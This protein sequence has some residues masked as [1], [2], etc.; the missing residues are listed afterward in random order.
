MRC[1]ST[2]E[3]AESLGLSQPAVSIGIRQLEKLIGMTLFERLHRRLHP[4]EEALQLY[5]EVRPVFSLMRDFSMR[6]QAIRQGMSGKLRIVTTPPLGHTI[7]PVAL[8]ELLRHRA[9]VSVSYD[10][11]RLADVIEAVQNGS[12][13]IGLAMA[14]EHHPALHVEVLTRTHMVCLVP[15]DSALAKMTTVSAQ[16]LAATGFIGIETDSR[17]GQII[18]AAFE[19]DLASYNP[20][21]EV[22][23]CATASVLANAHVAPA[24]V[25]PYSA[26]FH[27]TA[28]VVERAFQPPTELPAVMITRRGVPRS[29]LLHSYIAALKAACSG[30]SAL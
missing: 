18:R 10:V 15:A 8:R 14:M 11:R 12:A 22:R 25:D 3:A 1:G 29:R 24:I 6:A 21:V 5:E 23:Y 27:A 7:A 19:R 9:N 13:D 4:T 2:I 20:R 30:Y 26:R 17:I 28:A 16:D